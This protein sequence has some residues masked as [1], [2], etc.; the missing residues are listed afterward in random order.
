[1]N[2]RILTRA[3]G[4]ILSAAVVLSSPAFAYD[5]HSRG[6]HADH[7][8]GARRSGNPGYA[9]G[10]HGSRGYARSPYRGN[11][12]SAGHG[13]LSGFS[14]AWGR[15]AQHHYRRGHQRHHEF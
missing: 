12:Y 4:V 5:S 13:H 15:G 3:L 10:G 6:G 2:A 7:D 11:G 8:H 14:G 1:M 9:Y